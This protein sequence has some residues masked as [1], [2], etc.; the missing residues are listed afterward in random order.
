ME[1]QQNVTKN[2]NNTA[3]NCSVTN[4]EIINSKIFVECG[5]NNEQN[6][7]GG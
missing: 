4:S 7:I 6:T 1:S 5:T 3:N 2:I